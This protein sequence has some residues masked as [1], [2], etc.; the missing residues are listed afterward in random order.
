MTFGPRFVWRPSYAYPNRNG[1]FDQP[2]I[3]ADG[4]QNLIEPVMKPLTKP[5]LEI[6]N[7]V[8]VILGGSVG[9]SLRH[10]ANLWLPQRLGTHFPWATLT[11]NLAGCLMIGLLG[12]VLPHWAPHRPELRY[13]IVVGFLG[14]LT[15]FSSFTMECF[16]MLESGRFQTFTLY[17]ASSLLGGLGFV[18]LGYSIGHKL[19]TAWH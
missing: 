12:A 1:R 13:L 6:L 7:L 15:T 5:Y 19:I 16:L 8:L 2:S 4:S 14:G 17:L 9:V 18:W 3:P 11:V 10:L